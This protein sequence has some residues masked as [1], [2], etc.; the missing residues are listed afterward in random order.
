LAHVAARELL[1]PNPTGPSPDERT[2]RPLYARL[3]EFR[4]EPRR[5]LGQLAVTAT[6]F[7]ALWLGMWFSLG[8]GYWLTLLLAVPAGGFLVRLFAIQH[9]C[10]HGSLFKSRWIN[11]LIG[12]AIGVLT[13]TPYDYWRRA[14]AS[15]HATSGNLDRRGI[16]DITTLTVGEYDA[17][18]PGRKLAYRVYRHPLVMFGVGPIY[19]FVLKHRLP[20]DLPWMQRGPWVSVLGTNL[21]IAC[22]LSAMAM[23]VGPVDFLKIQVP[24]VLL[25]SSAGVWLF[26]VQ[27]QYEAA[28]WRRGSDW[29]FREA[30]LYGSSHYSLPGFLQWMTASIGLH[31]VH[32][33]SS[34][35]PNYRLQECLDRTPELKVAPR[36]TL[37]QSLACATLSLWDEQAGR[38]IRFRDLKKAKR[39]AQR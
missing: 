11:D 33:L 2:D 16:G 17:L 10:G 21:A 19:L 20:L 29:D 26:F 1:H 36:L 32:H 38:M 30:A 14:H 27:H 22:L 7:A 12:R 4:A 15:H 6:G 28:Y 13:L 3:K 35:I 39:L 25:G 5:S 34:R 37:V 18:S 31:H 24:L 23:I 9:D 8:H